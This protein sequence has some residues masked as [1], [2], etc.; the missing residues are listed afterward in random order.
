MKRLLLIILCLPI[1][2]FGQYSKLS[3]NE[4]T[5]KIEIFKMNND[6]VGFTALIEKEINTDN[7]RHKSNNLSQDFI[8][9]SDAIS[10]LD[11]YLSRFS[12]E[13]VFSY[14]Q[15]SFEQNFEKPCNNHQKLICENLKILK[16]KRCKSLAIL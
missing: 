1:I 12:S 14:K 6:S 15:N 2:G 16:C 3:F 10:D 11:A 13:L 7:I 4:F 9:F 5:R 8:R